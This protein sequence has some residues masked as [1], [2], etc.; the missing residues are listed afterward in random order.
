MIYFIAM[1]SRIL[2]LFYLVKGFKDIVKTVTITRITIISQHYNFSQIQCLF[3]YARLRTPKN[4]R[5]E[6]K[7]DL[8]SEMCP[9]TKIHIGVTPQSYKGELGQV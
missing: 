7:T 8:I 6:I 1:A 2:S 3:R 9:P 4:S 5:D